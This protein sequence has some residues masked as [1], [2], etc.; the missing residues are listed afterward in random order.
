MPASTVEAA[1]IEP[2]PLAYDMQTARRVS[3]LGQTKL[4]ELIASGRL[5]TSK[6][7]KRTL[8]HADSLRGLIEEG[9]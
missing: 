3:S 1:S 7:G 4:Y 2:Q 5:R 6:V 8:I 9:C